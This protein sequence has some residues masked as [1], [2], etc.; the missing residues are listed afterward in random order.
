MK[1][2]TVIQSE[3]LAEIG[4]LPGVLVERLQPLT[5]MFC[6]KCNAPVRP[7]SEPCP[8]CKGS[9]RRKVT[10]GPKGSPDIRCTVA[11]RALAIE[12][13]TDTGRLSPEQRRWRDAHEAAW[14][15]YVVARSAAEALEAVRAAM[16]DPSATIPGTVSDN[17]RP[18]PQAPA[19]ACVPAELP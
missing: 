2:E 18:A 12:V 17:R 3:I 15:L 4:A 10:A 8:Y 13:K 16:S 11:G 19:D 9:A 7:R 14:G 6:V 1:E 5:V